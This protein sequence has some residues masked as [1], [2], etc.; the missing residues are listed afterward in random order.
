[1]TE[2]LER[3]LKQTVILSDG[4]KIT[5]R[6]YTASIARQAITEGKITLANGTV[7]E[8]SPDDV[9]MIWKYTFSQVDGPPK[10]EMDITSDGEPISIIEVVKDNG[11]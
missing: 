10:T 4:R 11:S 8:L 5:G 1:L 2:A 7:M 3:A 9:L 6:A